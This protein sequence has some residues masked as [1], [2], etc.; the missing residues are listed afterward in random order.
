MNERFENFTLC[1]N[2]LY[3]LVQKIKLIEMK[4]FDLKAIH[5]M[6]L[7]TLSV[8]GAMTA[9]ELIKHTLEDKAAISRALK[10]LSERGFINYGADGYNSLIELTERGEEVAKAIGEKAKRAV[11]A[12]GGEFTD[13]QRKNLYECLGIV[14]ERLE[15]YYKAM[16][17][18]ENE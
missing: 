13:E 11:D 7:Y 17:V 16:A 1:I 10:L 3:K 9:S 5:V 18:N 2:K 4:E 8:Y 6:C 14:S 12:A 15:E